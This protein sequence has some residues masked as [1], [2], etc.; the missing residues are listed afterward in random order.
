M[1]TTISVSVPSGTDITNLIAS[2]TT[3]ADKVCVGEVEQAS[4]LTSNVFSSVVSYTLWK[5]RVKEKWG[6]QKAGYEAVADT[7]IDDL[8]EKIEASVAIDKTIWPCTET[9]NGDNTLSFA[10]AVARMKSSLKAKI[11]WMDTQISSW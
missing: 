3:S 1:D 5:A 2:F 6:A 11:S 8:A 7:Y 9:V 4:G 10:A